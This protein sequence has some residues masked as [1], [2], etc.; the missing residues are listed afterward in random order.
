MSPLLVPVKAEGL[1]IP[2]LE[3]LIREPLAEDY[4]VDPEVDIFVQGVP[5]PAILPLRSG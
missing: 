3:P 2:Q 4:F 1:T 5:Q